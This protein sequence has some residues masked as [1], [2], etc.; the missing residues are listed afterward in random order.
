MIEDKR[1]VLRANR[2]KENTEYEAKK[3]EAG[4]AA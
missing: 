4:V 2:E 3:A 1:K